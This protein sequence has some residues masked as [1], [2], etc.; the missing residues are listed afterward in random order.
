MDDRTP[1]DWLAGWI[2]MADRRRFRR[3]FA[4][5]IRREQF[6]VAIAAQKGSA[7]IGFT[8]NIRMPVRF[9]PPLRDS[10]V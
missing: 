5:A 6:G 1:G 7:L 9:G 10:G 8:I 2:R 4:A 3:D